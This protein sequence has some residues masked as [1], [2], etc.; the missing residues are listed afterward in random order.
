MFFFFS[1]RTCH[2]DARLEFQT[3]WLRP[4]HPKPVEKIVL[5]TTQERSRGDRLKLDS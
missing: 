5:P 4:G 2:H 1:F 3:F